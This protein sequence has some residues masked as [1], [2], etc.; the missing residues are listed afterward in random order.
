MTAS[1]CKRKHFPLSETAKIQKG[2]FPRDGM[3]S[4]G[5]TP[6]L[7][8]GYQAE[9][10]VGE[11]KVSPCIDYP[12]LWSG[13]FLQGD[14]CICG[15]TIKLVAIQASTPGVYIETVWRQ[16]GGHLGGQRRFRLQWRRHI[17]GNWNQPERGSRDWIRL[18]LSTQNV[19]QAV[20]RLSGTP[21]T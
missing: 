5:G 6:R 20:W 14:S 10:H 7:F 8:S 4:L 12:R 21:K 9:T 2:S 11:S 1:H 3:N 16:K 17:V 15:V 18:L 13:D 19:W